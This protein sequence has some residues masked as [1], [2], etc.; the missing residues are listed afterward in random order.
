MMLYKFYF[1]SDEKYEKTYYFELIVNK[2]F[3]P[4]EKNLKNAYEFYM[5]P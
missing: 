5:V 4:V 3:S 1:V 2:S